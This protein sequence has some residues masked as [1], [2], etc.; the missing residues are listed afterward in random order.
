MDENKKLLDQ[1]LKKGHKISKI[2]KSTYKVGLSKRQF[3][4]KMN[5]NLLIY[6]LALKIKY[7]LTYNKKCAILNK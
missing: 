6:I 3:E 1:W 2:K 4:Q 7:R 5:K